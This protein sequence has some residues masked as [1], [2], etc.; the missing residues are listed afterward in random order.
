MRGLQFAAPL[1]VAA[2]VLGYARAGAEVRVFVTNEKSDNVTV[3]D[4]A[5]RKVIQTIPVGKRPRGVAVSPDGR[6]VYVTNSNSDT[7]SVIDARS[8][9]VLSTV[10]AGVDPEGLTPNRAGTALYVVNENELSVTVL[11]TDSLKI[12]KKIA[13]G[14][15]PETAVASPDGRGAQRGRGDRHTIEHRGRARAV[16][17]A[18]MGHCDRERSLT[19][20]G[21]GSDQ[22]P[23]PALPT[24][25]AP[26][27]DPAVDS[28][29]TPRPGAET[30]H[31]RGREQN[32]E[33]LLPEAHPLGRES[34]VQT[35]EEPD[36]RGK[37][38][39]QSQHEPEADRRLGVSLER[40]EHP[41]VRHHDSLQKVLVP[42][43]GVAGGELGHPFGM[44]G[45]E[46][47][48]DRRV[49]NDA[50]QE[51]HAELRPHRLEEPRTDDDAEYGDPRLGSD[52]LSPHVK[53]RVGVTST[54]TESDASS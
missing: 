26:C 46:A 23:K 5:T 49:R 24:S 12:T 42:D 52:H 53:T 29:R 39:Q 50:P 16:R 15:E 18:P 38:G 51:F 34:V 35:E 45:Q 32:V 44:K 13:V 19:P 10:P 41:A 43:D 36:E 25:A 40:R 21:R 6:R 33:A 8:L 47:L 27:Q 4:A 14:K 11:D 22:E 17:H 3:I 1:L 37:A 30:D 2:L 9:A 54:T 28:P 7:L 48:R 20:R 31:H